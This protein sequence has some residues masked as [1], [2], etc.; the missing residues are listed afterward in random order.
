MMINKKHRRMS[1]FLLRKDSSFWKKYI[2]NLILIILILFTALFIV[3][4]WIHTRYRYELNLRGVIY[5]VPVSNTMKSLASFTWEWI[6]M[7]IVAL[8]LYI[9]FYT[10][11][12]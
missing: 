4:L 1:L 6:S 2:I 8:S 7:A 10:Y 12:T 5:H 11:R 3:N 9:W